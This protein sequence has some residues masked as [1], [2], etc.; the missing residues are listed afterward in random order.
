[1]SRVVVILYL[2]TYK[3]YQLRIPIVPDVINRIFVRLLFSCYVGLGT[4]LGADVRRGYGGLGI[5]IHKEA[6]IGK[7]GV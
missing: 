5:V 1:M 4:R 6:V 2:Q 3:L 7:N